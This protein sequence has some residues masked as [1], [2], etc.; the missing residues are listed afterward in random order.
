M[1]RKNLFKFVALNSFKIVWV[2]SVVLFTCVIANAQILQTGKDKA[3]VQCIENLKVTSRAGKYGKILTV[4]FTTPTAVEAEVLVEK[5]G[6]FSPEQKL[7]WMPLTANNWIAEEG[8]AQPSENHSF[9]IG[10]EDYLDVKQLPGNNYL[11]QLK[12]R[13]YKGSYSPSYGIGKTL[14]RE[15]YC[16]KEFSLFKPMKSLNNLRLKGAKPKQ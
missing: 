15:F 11:L 8:V 9:Q 12:G 1:F 4:T 2:V 6:R 14:D 3:V 5:W 7:G 13:A 16:K 10:L